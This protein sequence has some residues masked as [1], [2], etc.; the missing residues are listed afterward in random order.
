MD[1]NDY[2]NQQTLT[3]EQFVAALKACN[4]S[5]EG[6]VKK[7][8]TSTHT[9]HHFN[10]TVL[11]KHYVEDGCY[12]YF[13]NFFGTEEM[14]DGVGQDYYRES[15]FAPRIGIDFSR[16]IRTMQICD[17]AAA[18]ECTNHYEQLPEGGRGTLPP[19]EMY[20]WGVQTPRQCI[21]NMRHIRDFRQ[22]A[23]RLV[24]GWH[25]TDEQIM[26]MFYMFAALRLSGH[27]VVLQGIR[28]NQDGGVYPHPNNDPKNPFMGFLHNYMQPMF[29]SVI[30]ADLIVPLEMQTLEQLARYWAHSK[31]GN[32]IG[33]NSR[34]DSIYEFWYPEDWFR[35]YALQNPE[36]FTAI[37]E[38][39]PAKLLAGYSLMNGGDSAKEIIGNWAMRTM[40]CL[41]RFAESTEGGLVPI[42]NFVTEE[43][44][45]GTRALFAGRSWMNAPFLLAMMPS[46]QA[47]KIIYR[48]DLTTSAEGYPIK[49]ILGRGGWVIRNDFDK[50]CN[51]ELNQPYTERRYELGFRMDDPDASMAIIF[52]NTVFRQRAANECDWAQNVQ[53]APITHSNFNLV[54]GTNLRRAPQHVTAKDYDE[55]VYIECDGWACGDPDGLLHRL[56]FTRKP[57]NPGYLPFSNCG[58]GADI[59]LV[60]VDLEGNQREIDGVVTETSAAYGNWP[61][62]ILWVTIEEALE[63]GEA[64]KYAYCEA[65]QNEDENAL[66]FTLA[67]NEFAVESCTEVANDDLQL[68]LRDA[69]AFPEDADEIVLTYYNALGEVIGTE[70]VTEVTANSGRDLITV[71][72]VGGAELTCNTEAEFTT[73]KAI[74]E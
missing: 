59:K 9:P 18:D 72:G 16:F 11:E 70:T 66:P 17:P 44:E 42:D 29:P 23:E 65:D 32:A 4:Y 5:D 67:E 57:E 12:D 43:V 63:A 7:L 33:T 53:V 8:I 13:S 27:K 51:Y 3:N 58:C 40:P 41:P 74:F 54:A 35:Q 20:K 38:T 21:A 25:A 45:V 2:L 46:P 47:G 31:M 36:Y 60:V 34:G 15:Y 73:I 24:K 10:N 14:P 55:A 69:L 68:L 52:R 48:P 71:G 56:K 30:D 6:Q 50:D 39:M 62:S 22:W 49:P 28:D 64:I 19:I 37:R 1:F 61:D 26:N